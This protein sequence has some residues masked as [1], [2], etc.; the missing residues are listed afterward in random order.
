MQS[1]VVIII[2][3]FLYFWLQ[4]IY[5]GIFLAI[6]TNRVYNI[7]V[8]NLRAGLTFNTSCYVIYCGYLSNQKVKL[9]IRR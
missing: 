8:N 4:F 3:V 1:S 7:I 9:I 5:V 2:D 6:F